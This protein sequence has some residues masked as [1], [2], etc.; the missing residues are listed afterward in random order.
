MNEFE[1]S[2]LLNDPASHSSSRN[3]IGFL[4]TISLLQTIPA[5]LLALLQDHSIVLGASTGPPVLPVPQ[6][7]R[8]LLHLVTKRFNA[9]LNFHHLD[10]R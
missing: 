5:V 7:V 10:L 2:N 9:V 4:Q 8:E 1:K 3:T 6:L